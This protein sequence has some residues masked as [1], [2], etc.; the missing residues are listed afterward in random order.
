[1]P[2]EDD[3]G[4]GDVVGVGELAQPFV[5]VVVCADDPGVGVGALAEVELPVGSHDGV[6]ALVVP[7][8]G[9][10]GDHVFKPPVRRDARERVGVHQVQVSV[11]PA[12]TDDRSGVFQRSGGS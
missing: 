10:V 8:A 5:G 1:V 2:G 4:A 3:V 11:V 7:L 9:Q 12:R 6:V